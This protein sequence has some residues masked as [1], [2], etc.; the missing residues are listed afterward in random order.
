MHMTQQCFQSRKH[1][2]IQDTPLPMRD[3]GILLFQT[4]K[5]VL[6]YNREFHDLE[7][8]TVKQAALAYVT[9]EV[10]SP[11]FLASC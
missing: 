3:L 5:L 10:F 8:A 1:G 11:F 6:N 4:S 7:K 2:Q 9:G